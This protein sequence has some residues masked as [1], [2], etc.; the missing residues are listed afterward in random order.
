MCASE[1]SPRAKS[2]EEKPKTWAI[3][4]PCGK[5]RFL[6]SCVSNYNS[7]SKQLRKVFAGRPG[8]V[9]VAREKNESNLQRNPVRLSADFSA[10]MLYI[11][12]EK[13]EWRIQSAER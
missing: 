10:E 9:V 6:I 11:G 12:L 2:G 5:E 13:V 1:H 8:C 4:P 7:E 3:V